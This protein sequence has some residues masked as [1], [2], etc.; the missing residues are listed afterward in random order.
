MR[1]ALRLKIFLIICEKGIDKL[2]KVWYNI[3]VKEREVMT[4]AKFP[5]NTRIKVD[6]NEHYD[7]YIM[8]CGRDWYVEAFPIGT[9]DHTRKTLAGFST[10]KVAK[11][12]VE[13]WKGW[14]KPRGV[15]N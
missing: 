6:S 5:I 11:E 10:L 7:F 14:L 12:C 8:H 3:S 2:G 15:I 1:S 4:M 13:S 9:L